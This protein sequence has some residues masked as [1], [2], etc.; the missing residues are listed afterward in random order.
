[1]SIGEFAVI[2]K[3]VPPAGLEPARPFGLQILSLLRIPISPRGRFVA[4]FAADGILWRLWR[5]KQFAGEGSDT[6]IPLIF[7][8]VFLCFVTFINSVALFESA[9]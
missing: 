3:M 4:V 7:Q 1:M 9:G 5:A 8:C 6:E 2:Q